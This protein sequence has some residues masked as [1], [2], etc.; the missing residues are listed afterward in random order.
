MSLL[1]VA[2]L[3]GKNRKI[4]FRSEDGRTVNMVVL[5]DGIPTLFELNLGDLVGLKLAADTAIRE[6]E[7]VERRFKGQQALDAAV[8]RKLFVGEGRATA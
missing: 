5:C 8:V 2:H 3:S 7:V 6:S 1:S 4:Q